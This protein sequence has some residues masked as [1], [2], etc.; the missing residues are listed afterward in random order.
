M[1]DCIAGNDRAQGWPG[2]TYGVSKAAVHALT[3]VCA[4]D[5]AA[6][7]PDATGVTVNVCCPGWCKSDMAGWDKPT[8]TAAE[9]ADTPVW[10]AL[11]GAGA[12]TGRF[13]SDRK[14]RGW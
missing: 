12:A 4:R 8:K 13:F 9:G 3:R 11:G 5:V 2:T 6:L 7:V 10:L 1:A 14:E